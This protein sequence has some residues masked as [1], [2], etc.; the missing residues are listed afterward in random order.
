MPRSL[1]RLSINGGILVWIGQRSVVQQDSSI[2][3]NCFKYVSGEFHQLRVETHLCKLRDTQHHTAAAIQRY[4]V[5]TTAARH[6]TYIESTAV[7]GSIAIA[8][9][10]YGE[11]EEVHWLLDNGT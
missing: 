9:I 1:D 2:L 4:P 6:V 7:V 11:E 3:S 5:K 10:N 8:V